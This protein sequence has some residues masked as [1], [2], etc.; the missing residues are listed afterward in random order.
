MNRNLLNIVK[1]MMFWGEAVL[2]ATYIWNRFPPSAISN[3]SLYEMWYNQLPIVQHFR[4]F[5][6]LYYALIPKH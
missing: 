1:S 3:K 4:V 5:P 2:C 6:S